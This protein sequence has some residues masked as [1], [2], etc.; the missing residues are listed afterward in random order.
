[1]MM[2]NYLSAIF[3]VRD[4]IQLILSFLSQGQG[5]AG[6]GCSCIGVRFAHLQMN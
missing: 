6:E 3:F 1:M 5:Q 4:E 2:P